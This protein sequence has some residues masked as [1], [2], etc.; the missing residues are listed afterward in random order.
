M[1]RKVITL[2]AF[3]LFLAGSIAQETN[4]ISRSAIRTA[5]PLIIDSLY[6]YWN[7]YVKLHPK[8][9]VAWRNL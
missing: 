7:T 2:M 1:K 6:N 8:D 5:A 3:T 9:E 4:F